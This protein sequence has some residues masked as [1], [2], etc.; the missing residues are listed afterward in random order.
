MKSAPLWMMLIYD[1]MLQLVPPSQ[2]S[3]HSIMFSLVCP[4]LFGENILYRNRYF[5]GKKRK[6]FRILYCVVLLPNIIGS[7]QREKAS[8][9][10]M[11]SHHIQ[12]VRSY[13]DL[14]SKQG[15][16]TQNINWSKED[17]EYFSLLESSLQY[18]LQ[19]LSFFSSGN[20]PDGQNL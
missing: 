3:R 7:R 8:K 14:G 15:T 2:I 11:S 13:R 6:V 5:V 20:E 18:P 19:Y 4:L 12:P 1:K 17:Q 10:S 9:M 16:N